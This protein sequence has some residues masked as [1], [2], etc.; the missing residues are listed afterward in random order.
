MRFNLTLPAAL[1]LGLSFSA[2]DSDSSGGETTPPDPVATTAAVNSSVSLALNEAA[3]AFEFLND[4]EMA[5][6]L[7]G[8][9]D[10]DEATSDCAIGGMPVNEFGEPMD[11]FEDPCEDM[12]EED[13]EGFSVDFQE[14]V[15]FL[16]SQDRVQGFR[17]ENGSP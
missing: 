8:L 12:E 16:L 15:A 17:G 9:I 3:E 5:D 6:E 1:L 2:C 14:G 11:G 10:G 13:E 7:F 4:S